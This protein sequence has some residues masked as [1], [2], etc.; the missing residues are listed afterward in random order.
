MDTDVLLKFINKGKILD[1]GCSGGYFLKTIPDTFEK[2]GT[3]LDPFAFDL[4]KTD[5]KINENNFYLGNVLTSPFDKSFFDVI[6][7]RGVIEHVPNPE[8]TINKVSDLLKKDG[9]F[10]ICAT[11]NRASLSAD[12]YKE[13]WNL[14]H[15]IE[16]LWHFSSKNLSL[17]C[18]KYDLKLIWEEYAYLGTPYENF[19]EDIKFINKKIDQKKHGKISNEISPPFFENMMSLIFQKK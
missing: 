1:I 8:K 2:Y 5:S 11:P 13:N 14:Y 16:H 6:S 9:L 19:Y 18:E 12:L 4:L 7:M 17:L 10:Y 3:E 15:P